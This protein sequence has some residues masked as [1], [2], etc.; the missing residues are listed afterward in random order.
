MFTVQTSLFAPD[1]ES[2]LAQPTNVEPPAA[3]AVR[4]TVVPPVTIR[5]HGYAEQLPP[6]ELLTVPVPMPLLS[7]VSVKTEPP[8]PPPPPE[9]GQVTLAVMKPVMIA[10]L[11][12]LSPAL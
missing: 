1:N 5:L 9:P 4:L 8:P 12:S 10:P 6:V 3:T 11:D 2:Q 7:T